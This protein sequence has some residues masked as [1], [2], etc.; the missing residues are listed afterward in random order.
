M[1][2]FLM[3][4]TCVVVLSA[5]ASRDPAA[6]LKVSGMSCEACAMVVTT[7]LKK[8]DGVTDVQVDVPSGM[9]KIFAKGNINIDKMAVQKMIDLSGYK[10]ES[11][12]VQK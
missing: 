10:L 9:V 6:N 11:I 8:I 7:N 4:M 2:R 5:C 12:S 1:K 3:L